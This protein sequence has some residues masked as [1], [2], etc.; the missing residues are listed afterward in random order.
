MN[1]RLAAIF[2][3]T[4]VNFYFSRLTKLHALQQYMES[5]SPI[6][7]HGVGLQNSADAKR[8]LNPV[9]QLEISEQARLTAEEMERS[10]TTVNPMEKVAPKQHLVDNGQK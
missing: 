2:G 9:D 6:Q 7:Q 8:R 10:T 4:P 1:F 3:S 5:T